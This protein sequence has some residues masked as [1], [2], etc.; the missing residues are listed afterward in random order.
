MLISPWSISDP[1]VSHFVPSTCV[2]SVCFQICTHSD[3]VSYCYPADENE[4]V[5]VYYLFLFVLQ[6]I[7]TYSRIYANYAFLRNACTSSVWS[8]TSDT[9]KTDTIVLPAQILSCKFEEIYYPLHQLC[10]DCSTLLVM[11]GFLVYNV[12]G[13]R[14]PNHY[15]FFTWKN[16]VPSVSISVSEF[17]IVIIELGH[18]HV[19]SSFWYL[20][21]LLHSQ[22]V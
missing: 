14:D 22:C 21:N 12:L 2:S 9:K 13:S 3:S 17:A 5:R 1:N 4:I 8:C 20:I 19:L 15:Q 6:S 10:L 16:S 11:S 18:T 7:R